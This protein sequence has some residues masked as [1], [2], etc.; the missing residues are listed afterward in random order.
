MAVPL[1]FVLSIGVSFVSVWATQYF[2]LLAFL[3]RPVL[4]RILRR[5]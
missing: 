5:S 2:W 1:I 4:L 3:S